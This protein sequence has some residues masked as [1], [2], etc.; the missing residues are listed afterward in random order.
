MKR[1]RLTAAL[2]TTIAFAAGE[3]GAVH[4]NPGGSGQVL[5]FPYYT[6]NAGNQTLFSVVN[7]T[8]AGKAIKL[9]FREGRN[10]REV[11]S[12]NL[13]LS[14]FDV[15]TGLLFSLSDTGPNNPTAFVTNDTSCTV[16]QLRGNPSLP[17]L[18]G[19]QRYVNF[20]NYAYTGIAEDAGPNSLDRTREGHFEMIE[21]GEVQN[22]ARGSLTAITHGL[23]GQPSN[24]AQVQRAWLPLA[25]TGSEVAYWSADANTDMAPPGGGLFGAA[26]LIDAAGGTMMSY[27]ADA[28]SQFS[29]IVQHTV[30]GTSTPSLATAHGGGEPGEVVARVFQD[31]P[32]VESKYP[33]ARAVDAVSA[34]LVQDAMFNAF[35]ASAAAAARSEWIISFPTKFAYVDEAIVGTTA[36]APFT[37]VF[38]RTASA[39]NNGVSN[40]DFGLQLWN[41]E[42]ARV[43]PLCQ[44]PND[45]QCAKFPAPGEN[46]GLSWAV[47]VLAFDQPGAS[48]AGSGILGSR[49]THDVEI[50]P[51]GGAT[52]WAEIGFSSDVPITTTR[53][54]LQRMRPDLDGGVWTGLPAL[55]FWAVDYTNG[56][57]E[58]GV[59][60]QHADLSR[61]RSRS[62][63]LPSN[64]FNLVFRHSFE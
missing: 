57:I 53:L 44:F 10:S 25:G 27:T 12:L 4:V 45:P 42:E 32:V 6:V 8:D 9:R 21:M 43:E 15:W 38:P 22:G 59:L 48:S 37:E 51:A 36:V 34:L 46:V 18:P 14:P 41:E 30:P 60:S 64:A 23:D 11:L 31:G 20:F 24:C 28:L 62:R 17:V 56:Q 1:N 2:L 26:T 50:E 58:P 5:I 29:D 63:Y 13:Y 47:N 52:G 54:N 49:L 7:R 33:Q 61:H 40:V 19:G 39:E 35:N 16:P 3:A 55:G